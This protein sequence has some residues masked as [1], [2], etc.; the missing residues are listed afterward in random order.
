MNAIIKEQLE[1]GFDIDQIADALC[2][3]EWLKSEGITQ[4]E[5]EEAHSECL[6][7]M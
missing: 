6:R 3:G 4:E 7:M 1:A 5:S 2:D